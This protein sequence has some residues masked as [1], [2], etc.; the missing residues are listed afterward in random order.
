MMN[1]EIK[2]QIMFVLEDDNEV[3]YYRSEYTQ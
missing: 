2:E 1:P 3:I